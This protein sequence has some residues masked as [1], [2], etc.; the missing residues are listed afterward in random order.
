LHL[1]DAAAPPATVREQALADARG[2]G[3]KR[4]ETDPEGM[5]QS[6]RNLQ[7]LHHADV[8]RI[9]RLLICRD[10]MPGADDLPALAR[11]KFERLNRSGQLHDDD[12][13]R[14]ADVG[15]GA[16]LQAVAPRSSA[17]ARRFPA[18]MASRGGLP[19]QPPVR[20][21]AVRRCLGREKRHKKSPPRSNR[22]RACSLP[23]VGMRGGFWARLPGH[24]RCVAK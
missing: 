2:H 8:R 6:V 11:L 19:G 13:A 9:A 1:P 21:A 4:V 20:S 3:G 7:G 23:H 18:N 24:A 16:G 10:G 12:T 14:F 22:L 17:W 5:P 15:A